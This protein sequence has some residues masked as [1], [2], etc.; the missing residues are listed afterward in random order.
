MAL[1]AWTRRLCSGVKEGDASRADAKASKSGRFS[2]PVLRCWRTGLS[3][4]SSAASARRSEVAL[5]FFWVAARAMV[6][7]ATS[8]GTSKR[9]KSSCTMMSFMERMSATSLKACSKNVHIPK[10]PRLIVSWGG[11]FYSWKW[12]QKSWWQRLQCCARSRTRNINAG[13]HVGKGQNGKAWLSRRL[14]ELVP[15]CW[16]LALFWSWTQC[17]LASKKEFAYR[18]RARRP[19]SAMPKTLFGCERAFCRSKMG[20]VRHCLWPDRNLK[21]AGPHCLWPD[22]TIKF[23]GPHCLWPDRTIKFAGPHC[24]WPDREAHLRAP[25]RTSLPMA[26]PDTR[27]GTYKVSEWREGV[28]PQKTWIQKTIR[29]PH[30]SSF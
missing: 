3:S 23:A 16:T 22:R 1:A 28:Q 25:C 24:L 17:V 12:K 21:F 18:M 14:T 7:R 19:T 9:C 30:S 20:P 27:F 5:R 8:V 4:C 26:G 2:S 11:L 29:N 10:L 6:V 15:K 13:A